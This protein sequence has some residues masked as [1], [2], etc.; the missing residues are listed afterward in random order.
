MNGPDR[1]FTLGQLRT[2]VCAAR[3]SS[4]SRAAY[5]LGISQPAVSEQIA[6]LE[7]RLGYTLFRRRCGTTPL[8]T[9]EGIKL[10]RKAEKLL[11]ASQE[12]RS[13]E[14]P[15][16]RQRIRLSIGPYLQ[17]TYLKPIL[18]RLYRDHPDIKLELLPV[19]PGI[20]AQT[21]LDKGRVDL[22]V[23]T[24]GQPMSGFFDAQHI[25]DVPTA[26]VGPPGIQGQIA[27][28]ERKIEDLT[29]ILPAPEHFF[30]HWIE[31]QLAVLGC[32]L[33]Q[34]IVYLE[35]SDVIQ[36][37]VE[38][39][40]GVSLL[41]IEQVADSV[42]AGRLEIFGPRFPPMQRVLARSKSAPDAARIVEDYLV[43]IFQ[44]SPG[45]EMTCPQKC[46]DPSRIKK[47]G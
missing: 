9:P 42:A 25:C 13:E 46:N 28:G 11:S 35:F 26:L 30:S 36:R 18:P 38:D 8:L 6:M 1:D 33:R 14:G 40:Q 4:F 32:K 29:F 44:V 34:P 45:N 31:R 41:M 39:G 15:A 7:E 12:I 47:T 3:V 10:L 43:R 24:L 5:Q 27:S 21:A 16:R 2:F 23:Y 22:I 19:I 37:M 17:E 20:D